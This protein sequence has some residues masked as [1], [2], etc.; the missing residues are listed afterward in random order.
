M[1]IRL[2]FGSGDD[3]L[4]PIAKINIPSGDAENRAQTVYIESAD[5]NG[6]PIVALSQGNDFDIVIDSGDLLDNSFTTRTWN[7]TSY[8]NMYTLPQ[9]CRM[10]CVRSKFDWKIQSLSDYSTATASFGA[11]TASAYLGPIDGGSF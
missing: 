2:D 5:A 1:F 7:G 3:I 6:I 10:M 8:I 9:G 11:I 4:Y